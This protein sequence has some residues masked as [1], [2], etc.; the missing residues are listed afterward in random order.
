M[1]YPLVFYVDKLPGTFAGM[2]H[3]PIIR[4]LERLRGDE[5]I[6]QHELV[7]VRQWLCTLG[8]LP[9]LYYFVPRFK[10]WAEVQAYRKQ[11]EYYADDRSWQFAGFIANKYGLKI[12][13][14]NAHRLLKD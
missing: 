11:L 14:A 5:G 9:L 2:A 13:Q 1:N 4:I 3:G 8:L 10:L 12:T 6:R 7:H